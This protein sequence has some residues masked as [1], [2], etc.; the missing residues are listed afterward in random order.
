MPEM[1]GLEV[2]D[3]ALEHAR[4]K[5]ENRTH[6]QHLEELVCERT[7][8]LEHRTQELH[9]H[10]HHLEE[11]VEQ[12][13][14]QLQAAQQQAEVANRA[15][16]TF[17]ANMSHEIRTPMNAII[18]LT[19]LMQRA[20]PSAEQI[21]HLHR[22]DSAAAHLLSIINDVLDLSK[23]D[24]GKLT[25]EQ[26]DFHIDTLFDHI[27][28]LLSE[29]VRAKGL[30]L[31]VEHDAALDWLQGDQTR[32]RQALLNYASNAIKF[33]E[34]GTITLRV[35]LLEQQGA[36]LRV[37][38]EVQDSGIGIAAHQLTTL[39][40]EIEQADLS[41]TR[42]YGGTGLGLSITRRLAQLMGGE[43]GAES[44]LG[45]GSTFWFTAQ[46][47]RAQPSQLCAEHSAAVDVEATLRSQYAGARIL[48]VEDNEINSIVAEGLLQSVGLAVDTAAD[49][50]MAV[51]M[52]AANR[53][54]LVLMDLQMPVMD[55]LEA[56][57]HIRAHPEH[58]SLPI[59]AMSANIFDSDRQACMEVGMND[60][61]AKP[62]D[63]D[64]LF[65]TILQWL[66]RTA[67]I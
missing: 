56:A 21:I 18:G 44:H 51:A 55:G 58:D 4:L 60:F 59:L 12:R 28:A 16:S 5:E 9:L 57:R 65:S 62:V 46:L 33:T 11:L 43:A 10:R 24:A 8:E 64:N 3:R 20:E 29:S 31:K 15:K 30:T 38:F 53:Y 42:E 6:Q 48:L 49:G 1:G 2:I 41:T 26:T 32:L 22:I 66:S 23:I 50:R 63:P 34:S 13:T 19:H 17:L 61:V 36:L 39:F 37:R 40:E 27:L 14:Q 52:V 45:H 7:Q 25:L 35:R 54:Q 47:S 67:S